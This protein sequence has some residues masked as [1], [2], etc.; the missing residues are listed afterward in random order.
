M[1]Q[2]NASPVNNTGQGPACRKSGNYFLNSR[3]QSGFILG[4]IIV[5]A[6]GFILYLLL[7][8]YF[9]DKHLAEEFY[10][11]HLKTAVRQDAVKSVLWLPVT[12][13]ISVIITAS[14]I[15]IYYTTNMVERHLREFVDVMRMAGQCDFTGRTTMSN[16]PHGLCDGLNKAV[17]SYDRCFGSIKRSSAVLDDAAAQLGE[18]AT[19]GQLHS[20]AARAALASIAAERARVMEELKRFKV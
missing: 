11:T 10:R 20:A 15:L 19:G 7:S 12:A 8:Y 14:V 2:I 3:M 18:E 4:F 13:A 17:S 5:A 6:S 9:I 1:N 16:V